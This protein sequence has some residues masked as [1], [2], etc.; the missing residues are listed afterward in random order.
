MTN[1]F[2]IDKE[3]LVLGKKKNNGLRILVIIGL[4]IVGVLLFQF[5]DG[6]RMK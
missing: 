2:I 6:N 4:L 5:Y 1:S 3:E